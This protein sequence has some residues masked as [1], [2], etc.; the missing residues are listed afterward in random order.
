MEL[1][2]GFI[3]KLAEDDLDRLIDGYRWMCKMVL[4]EELEFRRTNQYRYSKFDEVLNRRVWKS[5]NHGALHGWTP[6]VA[7]ALVQSYPSAR[8]LYAQVSAI[9]GGEIPSRGR[10]GSRFVV[11]PGFPWADC[12]SLP[13]GM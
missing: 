8:F 7:G 11:V 10:A 4:D 12:R 5:G 13:V 3:L 2:S 9:G 6:A 1:V